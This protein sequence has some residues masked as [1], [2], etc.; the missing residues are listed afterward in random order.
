MGRGY[1]INGREKES[2]WGFCGKARR[3]D[4][5]IDGRIILKLISLRE[6]GW[7]L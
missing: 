6:I 3:K 2:I 4:Q 5:D 1:S 7:E